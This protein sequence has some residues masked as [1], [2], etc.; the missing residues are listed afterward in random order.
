M[1]EVKEVFGVKKTEMCDLRH[2]CLMNTKSNDLVVTPAKL[3]IS[4]EEPMLGSRGLL[5]TK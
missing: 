5:S 4:F 3:P 2:Q 1:F